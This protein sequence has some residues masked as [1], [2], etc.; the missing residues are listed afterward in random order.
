MTPIEPQN[1]VQHL[2]LGEHENKITH[3]KQKQIMNWDKLDVTGAL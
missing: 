3:T 2:I 1:K